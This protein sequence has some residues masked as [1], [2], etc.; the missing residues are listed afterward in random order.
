MAAESNTLIDDIRA[1]RSRPRSKMGKVSLTIDKDQ[2]V[3]VV[4]AVYGI[5]YSIEEEDFCADLYLDHYNQRLKLSNISGRNYKKLFK[6]I[7]L[8]AHENN[9]DKILAVEKEENLKLFLQHNF[10]IE[11]KIDNFYNPNVSAYFLALFL[12]DDRKKSQLEEVEE[13]LLLKV[14]KHAPLKIN[15]KTHSLYTFRQARR[16]DIPKLLS[17][18]RKVFESYPSPLIHNDYL[19]FIF[20]KESIFYVAVENNSLENNIVAAASA[21][22]VKGTKAAEMTDCATLKNHRG[23]GLMIN[24]LWQLEKVLKDMNYSCAYT[25]ARARSY[26]MNFVFHRLGYQYLGRSKNQC[27]IQGAFEDM[28]IWSKTLC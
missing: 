23:N 28:N 6:R 25:S 5:Y 26:G 14:K 3:K 2:R 8:I 1:K 11:A 22:L 18:Y 19:E 16:E 17:L 24:I 9:F 15:P 10:I 4:G 13:N 12:S 21:E 27:D 7:L 20:A